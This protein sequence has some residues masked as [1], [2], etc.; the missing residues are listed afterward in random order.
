MS[1]KLLSFEPPK[2]SPEPTEELSPKLESDPKESDPI[3]SEPNEAAEPTDESKLLLSV[4]ESADYVQPLEPEYKELLE[5]VVSYSPSE[6]PNESPT[7]SPSELNWSP[8]RLPAAE[9]SV[10]WCISLTDSVTVCE[11]YLVLVTP[12]DTVVYVVSSVNVMVHE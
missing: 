10:S 9:A 12:L 6:V 2:S 8:K 3:E 11:A 1:P 7:E 5:P 4:N